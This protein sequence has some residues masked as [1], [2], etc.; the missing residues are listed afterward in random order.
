[1]AC[2]QT[3]DDGDD[4]DDD[5]DDTGNCD[6]SD[7]FWIESV[8]IADTKCHCV[9]YK[10]V[11]KTDGLS[12]HELSHLVVGIQ[13]GSVS[14]VS[15]SRNWPVETNMTDPKSG[16]YGFKIDNIS[17]CG[18]SGAD[19]FK[20]YFTV[21]YDGSIPE[22]EEFTI[23]YKAATCLEFDSASVKQNGNDPCVHV[24]VSHTY[25]SHDT[26]FDFYCSRDTRV[27]LCM[28]DS[29]GNKI[30]TLFDH[31]VKKNERH[32]CGFNSS[33]REDRL[34]FYQLRTKYGVKAGKIMKCY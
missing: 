34:F 2:T 3:P 21:C 25:H 11:V 7:N 24:D 27:E 33:G 23:V 4:N 20:V 1:V 26:W 32:R 28:Y 12:E 22:E 17:G 30:K 10:M 19:Y 5:G 14:Q 9:T 13:N 8:A 29:H 18:Q 6:F 16:V 31:H 15:N